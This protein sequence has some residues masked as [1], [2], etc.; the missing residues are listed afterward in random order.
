MSTSLA[1][2]QLRSLLDELAA[3]IRAKDVAQTLAPYAAQTVMFVLDPPLQHKTESDSSGEEG[4]AEWYDSWQGPIGYE[5]RELALS[6]GAEVA[7]AHQLLR[8]FGTRQGGEAADYWVRETLGFRYLDGRWQI[9]HQ[10]QSVPFYM[11]GSG[12]AAL[13]LKP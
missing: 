2:T 7:F 13:D 5:S 8:F 1:E 12:R 10:H 6:V 3:A 9:T 11:D 4:V